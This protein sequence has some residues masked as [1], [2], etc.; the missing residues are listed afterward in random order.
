MSTRVRTFAIAAGTAAVALAGLAFAGEV[1]ARWGTRDPVTKCADITSKALPAQAAIDGLFRC[2]REEITYT[3][4]LWL[5][6]DLSIKVGKARPHQGRNELMTMPD[7]DTTKAVYPLQGSWTWVVCRDP[8]AVKIGGGNPALNCSRAAVTKAQ[9]AC[10]K[11]SFG[12]WRCNMTGT[13]GPR[14][15][16]LPPPAPKG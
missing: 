15:S 13:T 9:G 1:G 7:S 11:T 12:T 10:W 14:T 4:E 6:E 16:N 3:D 8:K 5:V 2:A